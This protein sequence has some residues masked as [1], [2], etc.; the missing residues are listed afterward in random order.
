M[1]PKIQKEGA[2]RQ[3]KTTGRGLQREM[4]KLAG[5]KEGSNRYPGCLPIAAADSELNIA[6]HVLRHLA[7]SVGHQ[8]T[9]SR[10]GRSVTPR[11][12]GNKLTLYTFSQTRPSAPPSEDVRRTRGGVVGDNGAKVARHA[13]GT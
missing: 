12:A 9:S 13:G 3:Y 2:A 5:R 10:P 4:M 11:P 8:P 1:Q 6:V 7:N